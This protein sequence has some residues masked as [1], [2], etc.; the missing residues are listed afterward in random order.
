MDNLC[1]DRAAFH[2]V[3]IRR[4]SACQA[5][6]RMLQFSE[7]KKPG[8]AAIRFLMTFCVSLVIVSVVAMTDAILNYGLRDFLTTLYGIA[9]ASVPIAA[10]VAAFMTFFLLNH[11]L[12]SRLAGYA[13]LMLL[14]LAALSGSAALLRFA[15]IPAA[16]GIASLPVHLRA[17]GEWMP[18]VAEAPWPEAAAS[19]ASFAAFVSAFWGCTR[20]SGNRPLLGAFIAP[21]GVIAALYLFS[22]FL[23][24]PA[25][26]LFEIVGLNVSGLL[27]ASILAAASALALMLFDALFA[28]KP[29]GGHRNA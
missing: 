24:G 25:D 15:G 22:V 5:P 17:V 21:G 16:G 19:V 10:T 14:A 7:M 13:I 3:G 6:D 8:A 12:S 28:R 9:M 4:H 18:A 26:A 1:A 27:S 20:L 11:I 29:T 23:S 2:I